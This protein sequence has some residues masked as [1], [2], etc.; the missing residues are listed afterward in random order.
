[1]IHSPYRSIALY[2]AHCVCT[3]KVVV[4]HN[5]LVS[6]VLSPFSRLHAFDF[7]ASACRAMW[8]SKNVVTK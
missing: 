2:G 8:F 5:L 7:N 4:D 6:F 3:R 1:M